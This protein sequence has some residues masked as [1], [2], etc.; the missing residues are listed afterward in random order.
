[1]LSRALVPV[2]PTSRLVELLLPDICHPQRSWGK[3]MFLHLSV[4]LGVS[5]Q[6]GLCQGDPLPLTV[7]CNV[8]GVR[9]LLECILVLGCFWRLHANVQIIFANPHWV[10]GL[11]Y[12]VFLHQKKKAEWLV[13]AHCTGYHIVRYPRSVYGSASAVSHYWIQVW[14][15]CT[16]RPSRR[17]RSLQAIAISIA[18]TTSPTDE[19]IRETIDKVA[20]LWKRK[21]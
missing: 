9:I 15:W 17:V 16:T 1:M 11:H 20:R 2:V 21:T 4:I 12:T 19:C 6:G 8:R 10:L 3:V 13:P 7:T 14:F 18:T 5:V